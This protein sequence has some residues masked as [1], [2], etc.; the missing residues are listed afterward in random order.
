MGKPYIEAI[1]KYA[2]WRGKEKLEIIH[3]NVC[4]PIK[5]ESN[6]GNMY[7]ITFTYDFSRKTCIYFL[8]EKAGA[9]EVFKQFKALV[10]KD[11]GHHIKCLRADKG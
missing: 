5:N 8:H 10:E 9:F 4:G 6:G 11:S 7:F 1:P 3:S 2:S